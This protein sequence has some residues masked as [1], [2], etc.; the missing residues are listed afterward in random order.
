MFEISPE[1]PKVA[2][3]GFW[4]CRLTSFLAAILL[5][6]AHLSAQQS[7]RTIGESDALMS[8]LI[9]SFVKP[10]HLSARFSYCVDSSSQRRVVLI[11]LQNLLTFFPCYS[12]EGSSIKAVGT[13]ISLQNILMA[14]GTP[15]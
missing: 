7:Q 2:I 12:S 11:S 15:L 5:I 13:P 3:Y 8:F 1:S 4:P 9:D 6:V 10:T 14:L